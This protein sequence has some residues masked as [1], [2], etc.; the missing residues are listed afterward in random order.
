MSILW[1]SKFELFLCCVLFSVDC[2]SNSD[3]G[4]NSPPSGVHGPLPNGNCTSLKEVSRDGNSQF[5][6]KVYS[7]PHVELVVLPMLRSLS[8]VLCGIH[9]FQSQISC[10]DSWVG[11]KKVYSQHV[12]HITKLAT[13]P[14]KIF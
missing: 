13:A 3:S 10:G 2:G 8:V 4:P 12:G 7:S 5:V 6:T 14:K 1:L 11:G 9:H